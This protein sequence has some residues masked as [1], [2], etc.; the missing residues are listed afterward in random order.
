MT[1]LQKEP[2]P[3]QQAGSDCSGERLG[4]QMRFSCGKREEKSDKHGAQRLGQLEINNGQHKKQWIPILSEN[5]PP[6]PEVYT[7]SDEEDNH[8]L[9]TINGQLCWVVQL[10]SVSSFGDI[11]QRIH[12]S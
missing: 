2:E 12:W 4:K 11:Y 9:F 8:T 1:K 7:Q 5:R 10:H 6:Y 3:A